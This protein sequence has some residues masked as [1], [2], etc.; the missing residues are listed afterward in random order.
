MVIFEHNAR[1]Q[2]LQPPSKFK[3][4]AKAHP[5]RTWIEFMVELVVTDH[6]T[7]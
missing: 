2:L 7:Q 1:D 6:Q 3:S 5:D 4:Q